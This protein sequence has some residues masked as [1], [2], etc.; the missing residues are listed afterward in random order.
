MEG[1]VAPDFSLPDQEGVMHSLSD[2]SG[3]WVVLYF[4][5]NDNS[6][7]CTKEACNFRD[8]YRVISQFGNAQ[9]IG[10]NKAPVATHKKF[11]DNN[12]L[13]FPLLSDTGHKVTSTYASWR[14]SK[15]PFYDR[16]F[17][18]RRN[19]FLINP[20]GYIVKSFLSV[21]PDNHAQEVIQA[22]QDMQ[23][24]SRA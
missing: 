19:T 15:V 9:V 20:E 3:R 2:Y 21:D 1:T 16:P 7:N 10:V 6:I 13:N 4:Y 24:L 11:A 5:P 14:S 8:E 22:L 12:H 23:A 18:T 17:G